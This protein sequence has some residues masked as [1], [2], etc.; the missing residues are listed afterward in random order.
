MFIPIILLSGTATFPSGFVRFELS[1]YKTF[2]QQGLK[3][4]TAPF[5]FSNKKLWWHEDGQEKSWLIMYRKILKKRQS[6]DLY[7]ICVSV[8]CSL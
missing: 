8:L 1:H 5:S 4:S 2:T 7:L 6:D 3:E